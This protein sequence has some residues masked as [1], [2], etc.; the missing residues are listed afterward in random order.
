VVKAR[1]G[2][3]AV[4]LLTPQGPRPLEPQGWQHFS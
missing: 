1:T 3:P 4:T 2:M